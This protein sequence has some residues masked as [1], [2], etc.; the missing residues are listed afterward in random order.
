[1]HNLNCLNCNA[2]LHGKFCCQCGQKSETHRIT[3]QHFIE[4]D[5]LHGV[6]H[7]DKGILFTLKETFIR[8][9]YA[10]LDYIGG[11]RKKY[12]NI[13]YM[14][15]IIVGLI[16]I[17]KEQ[18]HI[19]PE[20]M[21]EFKKLPRGVSIFATF[22]LTYSKQLPLLFL[23]LASFAGYVL[24]EKLR[25]NYFEHFFIAGY[26]FLGSAI[27]G[28][29][30]AFLGKFFIVVESIL[31]IAS[32]LFVIRVYYQS[33]K[34]K[35]TMFAFAWRMILFWGLLFLLTFVLLVILIM[36]LVT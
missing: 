17:V 24:F 5:L 14:M 10:A 30:G 23:P 8:P 22:V 1:M 32:F 7:V 21:A 2:L 34:A 26:A 35:Y 19:T 33:T 13:F 28:L 4:H 12:Y 20:Q 11:R 9:G 29:A 18:T 31:W 15:F 27:L 6:L 16:L 25:L 36:V 3:P